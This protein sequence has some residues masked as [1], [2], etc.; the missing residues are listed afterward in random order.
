MSGKTKLVPATEALG[1]GSLRLAEA[2]EQSS[3]GRRMVPNFRSLAAEASSRTY[4][5][6]RCP[7]LSSEICS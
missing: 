5:V 7:V 2:L 1:S 6:A 4:P 3:L